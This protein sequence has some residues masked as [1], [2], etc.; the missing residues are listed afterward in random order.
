MSSTHERDTL[1]VFFIRHAHPRLECSPNADLH[2]GKSQLD[3]CY[4]AVLP[5]TLS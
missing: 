2:K 1:C 4:T 3:L 5:Q